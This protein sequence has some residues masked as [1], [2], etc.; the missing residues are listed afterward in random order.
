MYFIIYRIIIF[1]P[2]VFLYFIGDK[3]PLTAASQAS[4]A[5]PL[6]AHTLGLLIFIPYFVFSKR[7]KATF[8]QPLEPDNK[9]EGVMVP[10]QTFFGK[11]EVFLYKIRKFLI[12][13]TLAFIMLTFFLVIL[14]T[15]L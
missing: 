14:I 8:N 4:L 7:V 12:P 2:W 11:V 3:Y 10:I 15:A 5:Q 1:I 13:L 6:I 9:L